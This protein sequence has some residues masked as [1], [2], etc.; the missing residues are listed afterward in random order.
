MHPC[1]M[2]HTTKHTRVLLMAGWLSWS[3]LS[4]AKSLVG[5]Q[6]CSAVAIRLDH[7]LHQPPAHALRER[8]HCTFYLAILSC[9]FYTQGAMNQTF[10]HIQFCLCPRRNPELSRIM[11]RVITTLRHNVAKFGAPPRTQAASGVESPVYCKSV[12]VK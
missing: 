10:T 5:L 8:K 11:A 12:Q 1:F 6:T 3:H 7:R 9:T 4:P 2:R